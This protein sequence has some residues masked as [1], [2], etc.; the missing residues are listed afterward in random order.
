VSHLNKDRDAPILCYVTDRH[1]LCPDARE[2]SLNSLTQKIGQA[3]SAGVDWIQLREKDLS[4]TEWTILTRSAISR[5]ALAGNSRIVVNDRLD[6]AL[7][8]RA[9]GIHLSENGFP[10]ARVREFVSSLGTREDF[11][12]GVSCHSFEAA[13]A[14]ARGGADYIVYGPVFET[15]SK[16]AFGKPQGLQRLEEVCL[17]IPIPVIAIGGITLGNAKLCC[18]A[19]ASGIAAIRLFQQ[20]QDIGVMVGNLRDLIS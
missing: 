4:T 1:A 14:A 6:V 18:K 3:A 20:E 5:A 16:V 9:G 19:G 15:P 10:L 17:A 13:R 11:L 2:N 7:T 12:I 8:E